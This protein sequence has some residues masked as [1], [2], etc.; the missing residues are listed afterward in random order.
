MYTTT[1]LFWIF[2]DT[3]ISRYD[4]AA[5][6]GRFESKDGHKISNKKLCYVTPQHYQEAL[7]FD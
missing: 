2:R 4:A 1:K 6:E 5:Q 3:K 7:Q